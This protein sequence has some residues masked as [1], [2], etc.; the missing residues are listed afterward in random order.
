MHRASVGLLQS[1]ISTRA[2]PSRVANPGPAEVFGAHYRIGRPYAADDYRDGIH[3]L[4]REQALTK[5]HIQANPAGLLAR[6]TIDVDHRDAILK[7]FRPDLPRPSWAAESPTGRAHVGYLLRIPVNLTRSDQKGMSF[8]ACIEESLRRELGGD[9]GYVGLMTKNPLHPAW[10][11]RWGTTELHTLA[12]M[13]EQ[14]GDRLPARE[15]R[16][17]KAGY[18]ADVAGLGRN[19]QLFETARLWAYEAVRR[20]WEDGAETFAAV[21]HDH[22]SGLNGQLDTPLPEPE[23]QAIAKSISSWT[24]KTFT[25]EKFREVQAARSVKGNRV[26]T[27]RALEREQSVLSMRAEGMKWQTIADTL[28]MSL[29]AAKAIGRRAARR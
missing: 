1:I 19:C 25:P 12:N 23:V 18:R 6:I 14:L 20:Y 21:V 8:A 13:A 9:P 28:G 15:Q 29:D 7:A 27:A 11:V 5:R 17:K 22:V 4:P 3:R 2:Q 10:D 26:K 16:G 24:W